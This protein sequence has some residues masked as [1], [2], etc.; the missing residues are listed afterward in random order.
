MKLKRMRAGGLNAWQH[1]RAV[2]IEHAACGLAA[3]RDRTDRTT[4]YVCRDNGQ[5]VRRS[6]RERC[7]ACLHQPVQPIRALFSISGS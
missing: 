3:S 6:Q 1:R 5:S 2:A 7:N 4:S